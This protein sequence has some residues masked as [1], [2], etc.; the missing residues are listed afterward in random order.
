V[1]G[2]ILVTGAQGFV[3]RWFIAEASAR[4]PQRKILGIGRSARRATFTSHVTIGPHRLLAPLPAAL[5][6][7][8]PN[9]A[10]ETAD[11][12][13]E[14]A[15]VALLVAE[16][17]AAVVHLA[18]GLRDDPADALHSVNVEGTIALLRA[19]RRAEV[20]VDRVVI[21]SSGWVYGS[22]RSLP[23]RETAALAPPDP[24]AESK[25]AME[26]AAWSAARE[27]ALPLVVARIFNVV[28]PGLDERHACARFASQIAAIGAG[29]AEPHIV[30]GDLTP[31]RDFVDVR[32][33]AAALAILLERG[34]PGQTYNVASGRETVMEEVLTTLVA[35]ARLGR[36]L[37]VERAYRRAAD[38]VRVVADIGSLA[39]LG[40]DTAYPLAASLADLYAYYTGPVATLAAAQS[41]STPRASG[42]AAFEAT[43]G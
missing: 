7:T 24:Y 42:A 29:F 13:D 8:A 25:V 14:D 15:L 37:N 10:Y 23:V 5:R 22:P 31:T 33:V 20:P 21:G 1:S 35:I 17:P 16:R 19:L 12:R 40:Y 28:G 26:C 11:I 38:A 27:T 6:A 36:K 3:G 30:V 18:S 2:A 32:D 9:V 41:S 34:V 39:A 43:Q 4:W